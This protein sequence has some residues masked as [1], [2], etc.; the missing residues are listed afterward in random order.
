MCVSVR[1]RVS[2]SAR[3]GD[4][5]SAGCLCSQRASVSLCFVRLSMGSDARIIIL[6]LLCAS[7]YAFH[8]LIK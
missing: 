6:L 2:A 5:M 4:S 7:I 1:A 3:A 8:T